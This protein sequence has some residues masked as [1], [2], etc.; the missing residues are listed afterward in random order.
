MLQDTWKVYF[1]IGLGGMIGASCRYGLSLF[2]GISHGFPTA[3]FLANMI[4]CFLLSF[5]LSSSL[6][7]KR[8]SP[9]IVTALGTGVI[10]SFTTF[11]TVA[12]ETMELISENWSLAIIYVLT[13]IFGGLI[14]A[15][16]GHILASRSKVH[17]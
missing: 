7:K 4:G 17:V 10:G 2:I 5:L 1:A 12:V 15:Y 11:S 16:L 3:T 13:S 9:T 14:L 6:F 8:F